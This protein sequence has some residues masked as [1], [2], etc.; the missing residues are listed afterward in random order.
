MLHLPHRQKSII[1]DYVGVKVFSAGVCATLMPP[2]FLRRC[3]AQRPHGVTPIPSQAAAAAA[4]WE[5]QTSQ[6]DSLRVTFLLNRQHEEGFIMPD[7][8]P[9]CTLFCEK[10]A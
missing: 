2:L 4:A 3:Q 10:A 5:G 6:T 9:P 7:K 8:T 1:S